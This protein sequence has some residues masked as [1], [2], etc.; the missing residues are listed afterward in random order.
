MLASDLIGDAWFVGY[1]AHVDA[2]LVFIEC[3]AFYNG[4]FH[5]LILF[6]GNQGAFAAFLQAAQDAQADLVFSGEF[7]R[8]D[9]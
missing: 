5:I 4:F 8:T 3:D 9:L 6:K 7:H 1:A 2:G